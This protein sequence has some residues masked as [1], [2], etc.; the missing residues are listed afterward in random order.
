MKKRKRNKFRKRRKVHND[1][2]AEANSRKASPVEA[3]GVVDLKSNSADGKEP[4]TRKRTKLLSPRRAVGA[5][6]AA[7]DATADLKTEIKRRI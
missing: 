7:K 4:G 5:P 1:S 2:K 3:S 6:A